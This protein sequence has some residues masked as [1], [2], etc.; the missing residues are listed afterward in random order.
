MQSLER[1]SSGMDLSRKLGKEIPSRNLRE[2]RSVA[3]IQV[4]LSAPDL[5][6]LGFLLEGLLPH[7]P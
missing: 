4:G 6:A 5:V 3:G 1:R 7:Q 2:K